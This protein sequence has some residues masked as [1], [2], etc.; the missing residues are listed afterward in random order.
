MRTRSLLVTSNHNEDKKP[1]IEDMATNN[2]EDKKPEGSEDWQ[3]IIM[4]TR[5][6]LVMRT[7]LLCNQ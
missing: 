3:P 4:R 2:N 1:D 5:S 7:W 6:L